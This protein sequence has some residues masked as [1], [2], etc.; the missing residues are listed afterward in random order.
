MSFAQIT[1]DLVP[2]ADDFVEPVNTGSNMTVG[3]NYAGFDEYVGGQIA[4][5]ILIDDVL[6]CVGTVEITPGFFGLALW[7][8][9]SS[10][11]E[12]DGLVGGQMANFAILKDGVVTL[13]AEMPE[14][15]GYTTNLITQISNATFHSID[16]G[17]ADPLASNY[18]PSVYVNDGSCNYV[19]PGCMDSLYVEYNSD[20][21]VDDGSCTV[22]VVYGCID[23]TAF[24]F[25][26]SANT[27]DNSCVDVVTG[28]LDPDSQNY[29]PLANVDPAAQFNSTSCIPHVYGCM[30][31][32]AENYDGLAT[33]DDDSCFLN[34]CT[35][36]WAENYDSNATTDDGSCF[37]NGC[38]SDWAQNYNSNATAD[39]GSCFLN[40]CTSDWAENYDSN[41][42][43]DDGSCFLNGC[44]F[45][46]A[47]NYN[48]LA[49]DDDG[50]CVRLGC[51]FD[52]ADNY[53]G[54]ATDDDGSCTLLACTSDWADNY[55]SNATDDDGSCYREGCMSD[56]GDNYDDIATQDTNNVCY[57][58]GCMSD[59]YFEFDDLATQDN[60]G[61]Q[62][63]TLIVDGCYNP[64]AENFDPTANNGD[65]EALCE[66]SQVDPSLVTVTS[67][68]MSVLFPASNVSIWDE[69]SDLEAG[70]IVFAAYETSRL[71]ADAIGYSAVNA[72]ASAGSAVWTGET[73]GVAVFGSD[74]LEDNGYFE[75]ESL[76]WLIAH[77]GVVYNAEVTYND[78]STSHSVGQYSEGGYISVSSVHR[79]SP[80]YEG[81]MDPTYFN[82]N[83]LATTDDG[84]CEFMISFGCSDTTYVNYAGCDLDTTMI[85]VN[86]NN[87]GNAFG[88]NVVFNINT[89]LFEGPSGV[90]AEFNA[91][92]LCQ[93]ELEGCTEPMALN[94]NPKATVN[95]ET[96]C[97]FTFTPNGNEPTL[98]AYD[99]D[100]N[101][102]IIESDD[103]YN[104]GGVDPSNI[105]DG[106]VD[107]DFDWAQEFTAEGENQVFSPTDHVIDAFA[108][109]LEWIE[110][111]KTADSTL[112]VE[113]IEASD[114]LLAQTIEASD[115][116]LA[117]TIAASD[118]LL[119]ET[120]EASDLLLAETIAASDLLLAETIAASDLL[121]A[122]T[123]DNFNDSLDFTLDS[124]ATAFA[125]D[126]E[127]DSAFLAQTIAASDLLLAETIAA[128]DLL[129]A[130]TIAA[131]DLLLAQ[132]LDSAAI[133]FAADEAADELAFY[134]MD[135]F[136]FGLHDRTL[137]SLNYHREPIEI[138]LQDGWNT[139]GYYLRHSTYVIDQFE[140]QFPIG[141]GQGGAAAHINIVKDNVGNF[142]WPDFQFD[143]LVELI[144]GQG[145]QVRVKDNM[146]KSDF[147]F[148]HNLNREDS[149]YRNLDPTVPQWAMDMPI[150][151]H[152]DDV[153][154]LIRVVNMLGQE[155]IAQDQ[156]KGEVLL[157]L[158]NDGTVEKKI[159]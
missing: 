152:P 106:F 129:L 19:I 138:D 142:W 74:G 20:A 65:Q 9:D 48:G 31:D 82:F 136:W 14:F 117:E 89:E 101:G 141:D 105:N 87:Y 13:V 55:D 80:Y 158:Y 114:L 1:S 116:L 76:V 37:L 47:D 145:Y 130:Q 126:E 72:I 86:A 97:N 148:D 29:N 115:L 71:E 61:D 52:W 146:G 68:N 83:P 36:D 93:D 49:T 63:V 70:D 10:T 143:G 78:E 139:I 118:L 100:S 131:S 77:E 46:W 154:T 102:D 8:D 5:F 88:E 90:C 81:C 109:V 4:A 25:D 95:K 2:T 30:S 33:A 51:I 155:V 17:C 67:N 121:L 91:H 35:S 99:V 132:T 159:Y 28:C 94:Y 137:D 59:L 98:V 62:C 60:F 34:G 113:T 50:S 64:I 18:D 16:G 149:E 111:T 134:E 124:A 133:A 144:P 27:N 42:T 156:F 45:D 12:I 125:I 43:T 6:T 150:D 140:A 53:D 85:D 41:A 23:P 128:S 11:N 79:G 44:T 96:I 123:I 40:G 122:E 103:N 22:L 119:A 15:V 66:V 107:S 54:L 84:S 57:R 39:D 56:W 75:A 32:W 58:V 92:E 112:L 24:N 153:R 69:N 73:V 151:V 3:M 147:V 135:T 38:T 120:I 110:D 21:N 127:A 157:Y 108:N 26:S 7:G 104:F